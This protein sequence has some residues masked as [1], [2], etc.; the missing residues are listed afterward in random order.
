MD[1]IKILFVED[2]EMIMRISKKIF[3]NLGYQ[4]DCACNANDA[5]KLVQANE[6]QLI[7]LDIGLPDID[8]IQ[9][10]HKIR[11]YEKRYRL[12]E[13]KIYAVSAYDLKNIQRACISV[14]MNDVYNKP[15]KPELLANLIQDVLETV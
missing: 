11:K 8:G 4:P 12:S 5:Y 2:E 14:G 7:I 10:A 6:Y 15:L 1:N 9:L 13:S 3:Q